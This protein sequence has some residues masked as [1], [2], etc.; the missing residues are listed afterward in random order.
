MDRYEVCQFNIV[1]FGHR[2]HIQANEKFVEELVKFI[3]S[4]ENFEGP[5]GFFASDL[6]DLLDKQE[7][8]IYDGEEPTLSVAHGTFTINLS[9]EEA[10]KLANCILQTLPSYTPKVHDLRCKSVTPCVLIA[11]VCTAAPYPLLPSHP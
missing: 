6:R 8:V 7:S 5:W 1:Y 3:N 4:D 2:V 11:S 9:L 10:N